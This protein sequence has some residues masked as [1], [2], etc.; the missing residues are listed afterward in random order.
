LILENKI[1]R[2]QPTAA[3][4]DIYMRRVFRFYPALR[5]FRNIAGGVLA[6]HCVCGG[7]VGAAAGC[8][9]LALGVFARSLIGEQLAYLE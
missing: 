7:R 2:S 8:D 5:L 9:L 3:P 4:T 6:E 1:K